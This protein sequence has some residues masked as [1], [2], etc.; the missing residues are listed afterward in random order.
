M[1]LRCNKQGKKV[2]LSEGVGVGNI[3][4]KE[5]PRNMKSKQNK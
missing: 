5:K 3:N 2:K 4:T 1:I